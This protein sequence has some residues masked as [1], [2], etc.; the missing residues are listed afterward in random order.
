MAQT[1]RGKARGAQIDKKEKPKIDTL[2]DKLQ[3]QIGEEKRKKKEGG[4]KLA[5][6]KHG[7]GGWGGKYRYTGLKSAKDCQT[8]A[9]IAH[10]ENKEKKV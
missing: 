3:I 4:K 7:G 5:P 1:G 6:K 8:Q 10:K 9:K 2:R